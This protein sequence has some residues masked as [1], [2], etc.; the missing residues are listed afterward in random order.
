[1][2][3]SFTYISQNGIERTHDIPAT[4]EVCGD[5]EGHG[6]HLHRAIGE[7]AYS[8]EEFRESFD[9]EEAGEYFRRGG[10]Y[11]VQCETC[12]GA[13][14]VAAVDEDEARKTLRGR[15]LL[16]LYEHWADQ[17]AQRARDEANE[18]RWG[19]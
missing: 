19:Y 7:H 6:T 2:T 8:I 3:L 10:R 1:M 18:R 13:R 14:V 16:A 17:Q 15:R 12:H 9:D 11:D 4:Y 5:C